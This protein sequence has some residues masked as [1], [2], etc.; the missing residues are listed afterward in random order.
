MLPEKARISENG[1]IV[2]P[3]A[4]RKAMGLKG[5]DTVTLSLDDGGL[6]IQTQRQ[7]IARAQAMVREFIGSE[8]SLADEL[9][10]ER[11]QEAKREEERG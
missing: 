6:H 8:R 4:F 2:I 3:A 5:G 9:I 10:A 1:R 11:R 7:R